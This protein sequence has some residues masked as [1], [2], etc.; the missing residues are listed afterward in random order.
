M[1][2]RPLG[3]AYH[4]SLRCLEE[5]VCGLDFLFTLGP[6]QPPLGCLPSSLYTFS[7][8]GSVAR[9]WLG[10]TAP[11]ASPNLTG[12]HTEVSFC[13]APCRMNSQASPWSAE[14]FTCDT[15][16]LQAVGW[17]LKLKLNRLELPYGMSPTSYQTAPPRELI[18]A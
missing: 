12:D 2:P 10:I 9:A 8:N 7:N 15:C 17:P 1:N 3:Y 4:Y 16:Q 14:M 18:L 6:A 13:T 11:P 5:P